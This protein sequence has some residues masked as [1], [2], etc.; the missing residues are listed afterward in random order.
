MEMNTIMH[1][2]VLSVDHAQTLA[3]L[4]LLFCFLGRTAWLVLVRSWGSVHYTA[5]LYRTIAKI[6]V[7]NLWSR[8]TDM[9]CSI[10]IHFHYRDEEERQ[11]KYHKTR[12]CHSAPRRHVYVFII[13]PRLSRVRD[14][15]VHCT[16]SRGKGSVLCWLRFGC[17]RQMYALK[18]GYL[19]T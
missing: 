12:Y 18:V 3:R 10:D 6:Y 9:A 11:T 1:L 17:R 8:D 7:K 14:V 2:D 16:P 13:V 15:W 4:C 19:T 5:L